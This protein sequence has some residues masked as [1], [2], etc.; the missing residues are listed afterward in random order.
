[1]KFRIATALALGT[2]AVCPAIAQE[3][4]LETLGAM[5]RTAPIEWPSMPQTG[6]KADAVKQILSKIKLPQGFHI[7]LY[8][9]VPDA[10]HMA[11]GPQGM[12]T[13]VGT[14]KNKMWAVTDRSRSG[15]AEEV[16]EFA[17]SL[18]KTHPERPMLFQ[19]RLP[20]RRRAEPRAAVSGRR[21][22]LREPGRGGQRSRAPR[23]ADSGQGRKLQSHRARMPRRTGRQALYSA[24]PALQRAAQGEDGAVRKLGI[25]G[26]IR[27]DQDGKN[28]EVYATGMRNPKAWTSIRRTRRSGRTTTR[29]TAWATT[30]RRAK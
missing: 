1:M 5:H 14:R 8:A 18:P 19:G 3:N 2:L 21:V 13:F 15:V 16:K 10:R 24:R 25:G 4:V 29:S 6:P 22:L 30:S 26:I 11:V 28:R 27:M 20:V 23:P 7:D 17:P 12:V 9:L